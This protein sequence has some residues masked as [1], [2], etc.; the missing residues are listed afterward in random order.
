MLL[1]NPSIAT[2]CLPS[3][4]GIRKWA[5]DPSECS[6]VR[7]HCRK[8]SNAGCKS[9]LVSRRPSNRAAMSL[10][11]PGDDRCPLYMSMILDTIGGQLPELHRAQVAVVKLPAMLKGH[12]KARFDGSQDTTKP[13]H[14]SRGI[15]LYATAQ[16]LVLN[17]PISLIRTVSRQ[18][19]RLS[20][21]CLACHWQFV[22][23]CGWTWLHKQHCPSSRSQ[24][25]LLYHNHAGTGPH[26]IGPWPACNHTAL[27]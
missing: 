24:A 8:S 11:L 3:T 10:M 27:V 14:H 2:S 1:A 21:R 17:A 18:C 20:R 23:V 9:G 15:V 26:C 12:S 7:D 22:R 5:W 16:E 13:I 25:C 6:A 4:P 19:R